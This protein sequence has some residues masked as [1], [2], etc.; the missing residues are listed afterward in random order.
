[1]GKKLIRDNGMPFLSS[2]AGAVFFLLLAFSLSIV[3]A[4]PGGCA[5]DAA[6][7][8]KC[9][10]KPDSQAAAAVHSAIPE[11]ALR[12]LVPRSPKQSTTPTRTVWVPQPPHRAPAPA[13]PAL[14]V[15]PQF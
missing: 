8:T 2:H 9:M 5:W 6:A 3:F 10:N 11:S 13:R 4:D 14:C 15:S 1:M 12:K 7:T